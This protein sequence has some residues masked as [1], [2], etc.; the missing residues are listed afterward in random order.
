MTSTSKLPPKMTKR[1]HTLSDSDPATSVPSSCEWKFGTPSSSLPATVVQEARP[2][3]SKQTTGHPG[4]PSKRLG[5]Q[6]RNKFFEWMAEP[7]NFFKVMIAGDNVGDIHQEAATFVNK[8]C[9]T[10]WTKQDACVYIQHITRKYNQTAGL[11]KSISF[12]NTDENKLSNDTLY[13]HP[14]CNIPQ[15]AFGTPTRKHP[16]LPVKSSSASV[17]LRQASRIPSHSRLDDN[18]D[19]DS[20]S[21]S[22]NDRGDS[23]VDASHD[24]AGTLGAKDRSSVEDIP[25]VSNRSSKRQKVRTT[26]DPAESLSEIGSGSATARTE[27]ACAVQIQHLHESM[28]EVW[29]RLTVIEKREKSLSA[30]E[31]LLTEREALAE[32]Y[33]EH[34]VMHQEMLNTRQKDFEEMMIRR[35]KD[36]ETMMMNRR[37]QDFEM[38]GR[39]QRGFE[40]MLNTRQNDFEQMMAAHKDEFKAR[41]A[42]FGKNKDSAQSTT[43]RSPEASRR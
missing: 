5:P 4:Q 26:D 10:N 14:H 17:P 31:M 42:D 6:D 43:G 7:L 27:E 36:F 13:V 37:Q 11:S 39:L 23:E 40:E 29:K 30:R 24:S 20:C 35:Q 41:K 22:S 8:Y 3:D 15:K 1:G 2:G 38:L 28:R 9:H 32:K 18:N 34:E 33:S 21:G 25:S 16:K 12:G 19:S